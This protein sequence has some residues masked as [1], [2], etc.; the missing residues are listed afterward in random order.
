MANNLPNSENLDLRDYLF[1]DRQRVGSLLAQFAEGLPC[2]RTSGS[3]RAR[4][5]QTGL[6]KFF[7]YE[8]EAS[9]LDSQTLALADLHVS[10]LEEN[11]EALG[12]LADVS[13]LAAG[14]RKNWLRGKVRS[15]IEPGMLLRVTAPTQLSDVSTIIESFRSL[16]TAF[17][18][19]GRTDANMLLEGVHQIEALYGKSI[20]VSIRTAGEDNY[21]VGFVGEIPHDHEF[22][23]MKKEL[24]LSQVGPATTLLTTLMQVAAVPSE[25]EP[26]M[27]IQGLFRTLTPN[28]EKMAK[29]ETLDRRILDEFMT[30][31][32]GILA[33]TGFVAAPKWPAISVIPLAIYRNVSPVKELLEEIDVD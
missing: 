19:T 16:L 23:P 26:N 14:K 12:M 30:A 10:Q 13:D 33:E 20:S 24:L 7:S 9:R 21:E 5:V 3:S 27:S 6:D 31:L 2:E 4:R 32:G 18:E 11:A 15:R 28:L 17:E 29:N 22:G 25:R 8:R 1:V